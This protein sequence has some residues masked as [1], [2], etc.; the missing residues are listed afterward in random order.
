MPNYI[1]EDDIE[2]RAIQLLLEELGYDEHI[3]CL[4]AER[5]DLRDCSCRRNKEEVLLTDHLRKSLL[6]LNLGI[7]E[8]S[9]EQAINELAKGRSSMSP[10]LAN[11]EV[12]ELIKEGYLTKIT[13]IQGREESIRIKFI[14][15]KNAA[16][17]TFTVVSQLWIKGIDYRRPDLIIY[18]NGIPFVF[19]E[20]KNSNIEIKNAFDDNLTTYY[21]KIPQL[22]VYNAL[23]ILS[24]AVE[25]KIGAFKSDYTH[26]F[27]W[28]RVDDEKE[29]IDRER[30][31]LYQVSLE[32]ALRGLCK[33]E[34]LIDYIENFILYHNKGAYKIIAK[35]HQFLGVNKAIESF[36]NR[37][38]KDGKLGVFWHTQRSGKS[39]SMIMFCQKIQRHF[40][41]DFT[42]FIVTDRDQL[43]GQIYRNFL[44]MGAVKEKEE[45]RPKDSEQL[46]D[47]LSGN[48]RYVFS[49]IHKFRY[50]KGKK[51]PLL[52][53]RKDIIVLVD[54]AHRTQY[55]D[56]AE[57]MRIG[58]P[59]AQFIAFT[60]TPLLGSKRMTN[61]FFGGYVSE[62]NFKQSYEDRNTVPLF[63]DKRV[64]EVQIIRE[65]DEIN[66]DFAEVAEQEELSEAQLM[67]LEREFASELSV[68]RNPDRLKKIAQDI[69]KH[70]PRRGYK[71]RGMVITIDRYTAMKMFDLVKQYWADE[72]KELRKQKLVAKTEEEKNRIEETVK[73]M[74]WV[75]MAVVISYDKGDDE[76]LLFENRGVNITPHIRKMESLDENGHDLE[77]RFQE[78]IDDPFQLVFVSDMWLTG[79]DSPTLSDL[80][81]D[82]PMIGHTLMQTIARAGSVASGKICGRIID[83]YGVFRNLKKALVDYAT[84]EDETEEGGGTIGGNLPVEDKEKLFDLLKEAIQ[85]ANAF[86]LKLEI[87]LSLILE[88]SDAFENIGL[89]ES[90]ADKLLSNED[91]KKNFFVY[92]NTVESLYEACKPDIYDRKDEFELLEIIRYLRK[93]VDRKKFSGDLESARAKYADIIDQSISTVTEEESKNTGY[94]IKA[95]KEIDISKFDFDK[96]REKFKQTKYKH[97]EIEDLKLFIEEKLSKLINDNTTRIDLAEKLQKIVDAYNSGSITVEN[98]FEDLV[99]FSQDLRKEEE[100]HIRENLTKEE[101]EL[102]DLIRQ[103]KKDLTKKE[104]QLVKLA[105]KDLLKK[106]VELKDELLVPDWYKFDT[107]RLKVVGFVKETLAGDLPNSFTQSIFKK[108]CDVVVEHLQKLEEKG[109][110]WAA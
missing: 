32:Y 68:I 50:P 41:G 88:C 29:D 2:K 78:L 35:N 39:F 36:R 107:S 80:Y 73:Y 10:M 63:Y 90:F 72:I 59:E 53:D 16:I 57:N 91:Y 43:D 110:M 3:N 6:K 20:L 9:I 85:E 23:N 65:G 101:L 81:M 64:P 82:K 42:F 49:L 94:E 27:E 106:V 47:Y 69:V 62:Y 52:S 87:N 61:K 99:K 100:R 104:E 30:V 24:N 1:S 92:S 79:F 70:F 18:I 7:P 67:R 93:I 75:E 77:Y 103:T 15:F 98:Y 58:I 19:F 38:G 51:Y 96:L 45:V 31:Q 54:E 12:Y 109:R 71:G 66:A 108:T 22:F 11:K 46:R 28:L 26:F 55:K 74:N 25:T 102:F 83:Y 40:G 21:K 37:E 13:N 56:L 14:D 105:A 44:N 33:K 17:N 86:C 5:E 76:K 89:F 4:T 97:I 84:G 34:K 8:N 48:K 95:S 60:G